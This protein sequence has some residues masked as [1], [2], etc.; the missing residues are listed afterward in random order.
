MK[1]L[2]I[3]FG[4]ARIGLA[5]SDSGGRMAF[6]KKILLNR[7]NARLMEQVKKLISEEHISHSSNFIFKI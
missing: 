1:Y 6:P 3:D 7:G 4:E 5:L 2:G